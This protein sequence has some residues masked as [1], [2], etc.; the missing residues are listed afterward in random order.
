MSGQV[1]SCPTMCYP[2][3]ECFYK[4]LH[5]SDYRFLLHVTLYLRVIQAACSN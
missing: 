3:R 5:F 2:G 1:I 4:F